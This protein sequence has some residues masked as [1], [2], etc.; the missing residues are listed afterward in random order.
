MVRRTIR[1]LLDHEQDI[2]VSAEASNLSS[3]SDHVRRHSPDVL[4]LDLRLPGG[5][6]IEIIRRLCAQ[7]PD[8]Q[9]VVVTMEESPQ[10]AQQALDAGAIGFVLKDRADSELITAVRLA[11]RGE[12]YVSLRVAARL[13]ALQRATRAEILRPREREILRLI[14]L[15]FTSREIATKLRLSRRTIETHRSRIHSKLGLATRAELVR[16]AID[17]HLLAE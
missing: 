15:G 14:A 9:I 10:F 16:F 17:R 3:L 12:E 6:S 7:S 13:E 2:H 4:V 1:A 5:S 8:M 11:A